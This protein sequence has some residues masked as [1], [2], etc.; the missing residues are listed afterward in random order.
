[1]AMLEFAT[2]YLMLT[3]REFWRMTMVEFTAAQ[4]GWLRANGHANDV[5]PKIDIDRYDALE[6][7]VAAMNL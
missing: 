2:G 1:M 5:E 3:P 6:R 4:N 7:K